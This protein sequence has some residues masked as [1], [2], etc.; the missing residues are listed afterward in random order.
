MA[1]AIIWLIL[2]VVII[3]RMGH[4]MGDGGFALRAS[5][6]KVNSVLIVS[7]YTVVRV[8]MAIAVCFVLAHNVSGGEIHIDYRDSRLRQELINNGVPE[9]LLADIPEAQLV[10]MEDYRA[11]K[12]K[13]NRYEL[14]GGSLAVDTVFIERADGNLVT[15]QYFKWLEGGSNWIDS[16]HIWDTDDGNRPEI[17]G[18][19]LIYKKN[20]QN[21]IMNIPELGFQDNDNAVFGKVQYPAG[22]SRQRGYVILYYNVENSYIFSCCLDFLHQNSFWLDYRDRLDQQTNSILGGQIYSLQSYES[23]IF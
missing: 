19:G 13:Q 9:E 18:S 14:D 5:P 6:V 15:I 12:H 23:Y 16:I 7:A 2:A 8:F 1:M 17:V 22:V 4:K 11:I 20:G 3:A 10:V 21:Y